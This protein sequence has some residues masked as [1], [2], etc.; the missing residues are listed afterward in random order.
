MAFIA[1]VVFTFVF[2]LVVLGTT[3][4]KKGAGNFAGLAIGLALV[5]VHIIC[6]PLTGTSVNPARSL[7]PA[8]FAGGSNL[9]QL[10]LFIVAPM[11][12]AALSAGVWAIF[13]C[14]KCE[15]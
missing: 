14:E 11:I 4:S 1:E 10:W 13:S 7:G 5:L 8:L 9:A 3:D 15:K 6:I 2:V 12:G